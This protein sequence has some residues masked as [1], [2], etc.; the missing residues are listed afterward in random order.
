MRLHPVPEAQR[1]VQVACPQEHLAAAVQHVVHSQLVPHALEI[2]TARPVGG[3]EP[4]LVLT[5]LLTG[6]E[7]GAD[8]R[9]RTL[10]AELDRLLPGEGSAILHTA[11]DGWGSLTTPGRPVASTGGDGTGPEATGRADRATVLKTTARLTGIP[12][13]VAA[14]VDLGLEPTGSAGTGVLY[15]LAAP[16]TDPDHLATAV[17]RLRAVSTRLGGSTVVLDAPA[18]VKERVHSWGPVPAI[19]LMRRVKDEFDPTRV[20]APGRFVGGL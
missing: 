3:L 10:A 11:P 13:L 14:I 2:G 9:A 1:W 4:G 16:G 7:G 18:G 12:E 20:L 19:D 5:T 6:T 8:A 15:A 17:D